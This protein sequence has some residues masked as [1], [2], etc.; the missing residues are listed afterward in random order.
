[1]KAC[2]NKLLSNPRAEV[3][4][5]RWCGTRSSRAPCRRSISSPILPSTAQR[6]G[7]QTT[8][9]FISQL[10]RCLY[11]SLESKGV[12]TRELIEGDRLA[13]CEPFHVIRQQARFPLAVET[14]QVEQSIGRP[15][16]HATGQDGFLEFGRR[17][18]HIVD[19]A[20]RNS[21]GFLGNVLVGKTFTSVYT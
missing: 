16:R 19:L 13:S 11:L 1:M 6:H 15:F 17:Q 18:V 7:T 9:D 2:W 12:V 21:S 4:D 5:R 3:S 8:A 10:T 14:L 20:S